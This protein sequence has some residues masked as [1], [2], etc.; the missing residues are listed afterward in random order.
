[1][2]ET[3]LKMLVRAAIA[4]NQARRKKNAP[5]PKASKAKARKSKKA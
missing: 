4:Y 2:K 5:K 1:V 3:A